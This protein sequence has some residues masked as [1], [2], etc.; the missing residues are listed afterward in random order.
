MSNLSRR[1]LISSIAALPALA[2]PAVAI[3]HPSDAELEKLLQ[4][5]QNTWEG[6]DEACTPREATDLLWFEWR[7]LNPDASQYAE[8]AFKEECG[9]FAA[10][11]GEERANALVDA[12]I[13]SICEVRA[14]S[15]RGLIAKARAYD[16]VNGTDPD[17]PLSILDDLLEMAAGQSGAS[18]KY[19]E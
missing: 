2:L 9:Y 13:E 12:A 17:I 3:S 8:N 18:P 6:L 19:S 16:A 10:I 7:R 4:Q 11:T 1:L 14:R 5:L 15:L